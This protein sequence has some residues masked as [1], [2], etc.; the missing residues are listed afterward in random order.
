MD[1]DLEPGGPKTCESGGSGSGSATLKE[2][3]LYLSCCD[4]ISSRKEYRKHQGC[5]PCCSYTNYRNI[6]MAGA[7]AP[8]V[9][10]MFWPAG[11]V[12]AAFSKSKDDK[13]NKVKTGMFNGS[14]V[15]L[16]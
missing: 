2:G 11:Y 14:Q 7:G 10:P 1:P 15:E 8:F 6:T 16:Y 4:K 3:V 5:T 13:P 9:T 12:L